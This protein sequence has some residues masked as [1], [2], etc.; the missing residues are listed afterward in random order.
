MQE[1]KNK[2]TFTIRPIQDKKLIPHALLLSADPS[3]ESLNSYLESSIAFGAF[4]N[5]ELLGIVLAMATRPFTM[6]LLNLAVEEKHQNSGIGKALIRKTIETA[7]HLGFHTIEVGT[8]NAGIGQLA[9][10]QKCGFRISGIIPDY[11]VRHYPDPIEENGI[12][13]RDMIRLSLEL[14]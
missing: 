12:P 1:G 2:K 9:L 8:G 3:E 14:R 13:C 10:Y 6:E 4:R 11:F 7:R 5:S